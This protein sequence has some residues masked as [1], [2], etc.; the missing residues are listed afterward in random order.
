MSMINLKNS[1]QLYPIFID[2]GKRYALSSESNW[3]HSRL[4]M[5]VENPQASECLE[6]ALVPR[7]DGR[8]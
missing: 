8:A 4:V 2:A 7:R 3:M 6:N 1:R 5:R